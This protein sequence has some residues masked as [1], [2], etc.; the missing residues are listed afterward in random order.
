M[1][2]KKKIKDKVLFLDYLDLLFILKNVLFYFLFSVE[3]DSF[4]KI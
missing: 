3:K 4:L 1:R 2:E